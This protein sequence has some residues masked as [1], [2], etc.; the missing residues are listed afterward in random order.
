MKYNFKKFFEM[1]LQITD[2]NIASKKI[3]NN[4]ETHFI[5]PIYNSCPAVTCEN[6]LFSHKIQ[7][8]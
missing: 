8:Y 5:F 2:H 7:N 4:F 3:T 1:A 6:F